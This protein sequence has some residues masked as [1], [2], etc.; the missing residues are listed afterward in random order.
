MYRYELASLERAQSVTDSNETIA[1]KLESDYGVCLTRGFVFPIAAKPLFCE[2][3][4]I[5]LINDI[6]AIQYDPTRGAAFL[7]RHAPSDPVFFSNI[8]DEAMNVAEVIS[9]RSSIRFLMSVVSPEISDAFYSKRK[10][11]TLLVE[12]IGPK[13][14]IKTETTYEEDRGGYGRGLDD[15]LTMSSNRRVDI[16]TMDYFRVVSYTLGGMK[17]LVSHEVD[18]VHPTTN[19]SIELKSSKIKRDRRTGRIFDL[20]SDFYINVWRQMVLSG[21]PILKIGRHENGNVSNLISMTVDEVRN[22]AG[23]S[24]ADAK[25]YFGRLVVVLRWISSNLA[26]GKQALIE[27]REG[28]RTLEM[29]TLTAA[30]RRPCVSQSVRDKLTTP[31]AHHSLI[32]LRIHPCKKKHTKTLKRL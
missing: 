18:C 22:A 15:V 32:K 28:G 23:I 3:T 5:F 1:T 20:K 27:Y 9:G 17:F 2:K 11:F 26:D 30:E 10:A 31:P 12:K 6:D 7:N 14:I 8:A 13:L 24:P 4:P 16:S 29:R 21:T 19:H 25:R